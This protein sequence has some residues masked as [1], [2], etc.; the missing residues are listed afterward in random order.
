[1][2]RPPSPTPAF[3]VMASSRIALPTRIRYPSTS[4]KQR[5]NN[6]S[7][8]NDAVG[9]ATCSNNEQCGTL[10]A[11]EISAAAASTS[12]S[13]APSTT[14]KGLTTTTQLSSISQSRTS[15]T[16]ENLATSTAPSSTTGSV[17][18]MIVTLTSL[19]NSPVSLTL[20]EEAGIGAGAGVFGL[21][22][23]GVLT[24][25]IRKRQKR[26]GRDTGAEVTDE[27]EVKRLDGFP[28]QKHELGGRSLYE[29]NFEMVSPFL[30]SIPS[31][32]AGTRL[33]LSGAK[34]RTLC[35]RSLHRLLN[36]LGS[37]LPLL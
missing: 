12:S 34:S 3:V 7:I 15:V 13:Q 31:G 8:P 21:V 28:S 25:Y 30:L 24:F 1:V 35:C 29:I 23:L 9:Q 16:V 10:N 2:I 22:C 36:V 5:F 18:A 26:G 14:L 27:K 19:S 20:G 32:N 17:L 11:T 6:A 37:I 4:V 33:A